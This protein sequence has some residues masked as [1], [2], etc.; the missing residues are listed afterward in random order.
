M[1]VTLIEPEQFTL[2]L[3]S[4]AYSPNSPS[5]TIY[6]NR[7]ISEEAQLQSGLGVFLEKDML[8]PGLWRVEMDGTCL[9][10]HPLLNTVEDQLLWRCSLEERGAG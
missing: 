5:K 8:P 4:I 10:D 7:N 1:I 9:T 3:F 6:K 2:L